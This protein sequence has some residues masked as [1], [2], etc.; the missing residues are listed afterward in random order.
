MGNGGKTQEG[1]EKVKAA[2]L[3]AFGERKER[4]EI[5]TGN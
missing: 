5:E 1:D 4:D 3:A 2:L